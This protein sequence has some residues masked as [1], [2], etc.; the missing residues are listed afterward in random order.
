VNTGPRR[1]AATQLWNTPHTTGDNRPDDRPSDRPSNVV[2]IGREMHTGQLRIAERFVAAY[3]GRLLY[4]HGSPGWHYWGGTHWVVDRDG[5]TRR[6]LV[7]LFKDLRHEA[8]DMRDDD[9]RDRLWGDVRK[10]ESSGGMGGVLDIAKFMKPMTLA[11]EHANTD[12]YLFNATNGTLNLDTGELQPHQPGDYITRCAGTGVDLDARSDLWDEFLA[13]VLPD[14]AVRDYLARVF[15]LAMLGAVKEHMLPILTGTGGNGKGV[16]IGAMLDAF[17]DYG[18]TVDPKLI[19]RTKHERHDTFVADLDGARLVVTSETNEGEVLAAATVKRLTGG[20][21]IRAN[22]MRSDPYEFEPSHSLLYMT[23][24]TPQVSA[25]DKAMWRRLTVVPFDVTIT[26]PDVHLP[27]KLREHLPAVLA[28]AVNGWRD[29]VRQGMTPPA[30]V[31]R[32]TDAYREESDPV[33]QFLNEECVTGPMLK[34]K[35][36]VLFQAYATWAMRMQVPSM[37][38]KDFGQRMTD[39][40]ERKRGTGGAYVYTGIGLAADE[41]DTDTVF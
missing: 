2:P 29:Y 24:H 25:D 13:T 32:R 16:C 20:D 15:G 5:V 28:W 21:K 7:Q 41:D 26:E 23:N 22:R 8:A 36:S 6:S 33:A 34:V 31:R 11:A 19:M 37:T 4:I 3:S 40:A 35:A 9:E 30:A 18:I 1:P 39:R 38:Q 14:E 17:G 12:P 10:C 27:D